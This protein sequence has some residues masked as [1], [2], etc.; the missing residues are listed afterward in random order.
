MLQKALFSGNFGLYVLLPDD[1]WNDSQAISLKYKYK[2]RRW[3]WECCIDDYIDDD[4]QQL[5]SDG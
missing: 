1:N 4:L 3:K 5:L 2:Q